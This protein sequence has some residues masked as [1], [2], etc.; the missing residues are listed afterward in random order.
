MGSKGTNTVQT[1]SAP[2]AD[3]TAAFN[4][5]IGQAQSTAATPYSNYPGQTVA[6]L[7]PDQTAA[8]G[9][10]EGLTANGGVQQPYL[11]AANT[12]INNAATGI[13]PANFGST[14]SQY[15][16]PYTTQVVQAT[17]AQQ[18]NQN[19]QQQQQVASSAAQSGAYGGDR[20][21]VAQGITA[22]QQQLAEAPVIAGLEN[23]GFTNATSAA[24]ANQWLNSQAG[25]GEA[26]LGSEAQATGLQGASALLQTGG[27]EQQ[28][29][30]ENLNIPYEQYLAAEAYPF[31]TAGWEANIEEGLGSASGGT[32]ST[33]SP[34]A[35]SASQI[36]GLGIGGL[37]VAGQLG[38]F[39]SGAS[40]ISGVDPYA[41]SMAAEA[42]AST[43]TGA[44]LSAANDGLGAIYQR[45][46][47]I[48][49]RALGGMTPGMPE[50]APVNIGVPDAGISVVPGA[51]GIADI[52]A[53]KGFDPAIKP[54]GTTSTTTGGSGESGI[55]E[56]LQTAGALAAG[57]YGGPAGAVAAGALNSE[58]HFNRGGMIPRFADGGS[59][60]SLAAPQAPVGLGMQPAVPDVAVAVVPNAP[61][62]HGGKGPP[63]A[64]RPVST[65]PPSVGNS[66]AL[67]EQV[68][69]LVKDANN[70]WGA[71][72]DNSQ[73]GGG[74]PHRDTGGDA[75]AAPWY[76]PIMQENLDNQMMT[77]LGLGAATSGAGM[78]PAS[79]EASTDDSA[80]MAAGGMV[81]RQHFDMGGMS[82]SQDVPSW[83]RNEEQEAT[84]RHGVLASPIAGRTDQLA[85]SPASGSYVVPADVVSGIGEGN[86]LAGANVMQR[87]L[88]TGPHGLRMP[89]ERM[90]KGPPRPPPAYREGEGDDGMATGG[91]LQGFAAGGADDEPVMNLEGSDDDGWTDGV[92]VPGSGR[93]PAFM[94]A[95]SAEPP[96]G[97]VPAT[98]LPPTVVTAHRAG[99]PSPKGGAPTPEPVAPD[100]APDTWD[101]PS[102]GGMRPPNGS[103]Q[104]APDVGGSTRGSLNS[105]FHTAQ[106]DPW[107][108]L[109]QAGFG[110]AAGRSPHALENIGSGAEQGVKSYIQQRQQ[111]N[112]ADL[113]AQEIGA[114]LADTQAYREGML[115]IRGQNADTAATKVANTA[116][117]QAGVVAVRNRAADL[118]AAGLDERTANQQALVELGQGKLVV[119][120]QAQQSQADRRTQQTAQ[121][122]VGAAQRQ[123]AQDA[124]EAYRNAT[125]ADKATARANALQAGATAADIRMIDAGGH[126]ITGQPNLTPQ[127]AHTAR[128]GLSNQ[129]APGGA[130]ATTPAATAPPVPGA[131]QAQDGAWYVPTPNGGWGRLNP[132]AP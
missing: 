79:L 130:P 96:S 46:G 40:T 71:S 103:R 121:G 1:Q 69:G 91:G 42:A 107:L 113:Q 9:Q 19:A 122:W 31:Q 55:G 84:N 51:D 58:V 37:G 128:V 131:R 93:A 118:Q 52:S 68:M 56:V 100:A 16:S 59:S 77:S 2:P 109:A 18:Q 48:P 39:G 28:Q 6:Q 117:Y 32:S 23:T 85:I 88:E 5:A 120:Q 7:S 82:L 116:D 78:T 10:V 3:V 13:D 64:P 20:E 67:P 53:G 50:A 14:V 76:A 75:T 112:Q 12:D 25:A 11:T 89:A 24:E 119:S 126:S 45:G 70:N 65:A 63:Q 38:A 17:E 87:I 8:F 92:A 124:L 35:S 95:A 80:G 83:T 98:V 86:T 106:A 129:N 15:E 27:L 36:A 30:Q 101:I 123:K 41:A 127:Q 49:R 114:R 111:A 132:P 104:S 74:L 94:P 115:G 102:G 60:L 47:M 4:S 66:I 125:E 54:T 108:A 90:G 81:P 72:A 34:A 97:M 57:I 26:N 29:A 105:Q 44:T 61:I 33:T 62:A 110:M 22:G 99:L 43:G 21:A 73:R